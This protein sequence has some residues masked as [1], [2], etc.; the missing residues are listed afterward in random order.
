MVHLIRF[1]SNRFDSIP[2]RCSPPSTSS[3]RHSSLSTM[4]EL[5]RVRVVRRATVGTADPTGRSRAG[6]SAHRNVNFLGDSDP[7]I[8][9]AASPASAVSM[10]RH[11]A[12]LPATPE[13]LET[14]DTPTFPREGS[15]L[16]RD[17]AP[18][19]SNTVRRVSAVSAVSARP[20][21]TSSVSKS[22]KDRFYGED[23]GGQ[24][25]DFDRSR[26]DTPPQSP[27]SSAPLSSHRRA[28][29]I[30]SARLPSASRSSRRRVSA[31]PLLS[32]AQPPPLSR[33]YF[34]SDFEDDEEDASHSAI[35]DVIDPS[36]STAADLS[37]I[38]TSI[39]IPCVA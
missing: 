31:P 28:S 37:S 35:L 26:G 18:S 32:N 2:L 24:G 1:D 33:T 15:V 20:R 4:D 29:L 14:L 5:K 23:G 17:Y 39:C 25:S 19:P 6:S 21:R 38:G 10:L 34:E 8:S 11:S 9:L 3:F 27:P 13:S 12:R 36:V 16:A 22:L 7:P 30:G